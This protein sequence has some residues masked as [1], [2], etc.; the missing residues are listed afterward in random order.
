MPRLAPVTSTVWL[1]IFI[2]FSCPLFSRLSLVMACTAVRHRVRSST[3]ARRGKERRF[4]C[5]PRHG[6]VA[7]RRLALA[8]ED[9]PSGHSSDGSGNADH[10]E[11]GAE[12]VDARSRHERGR[13]GGDAGGAADLTHGLDQARRQPRRRF[14]DSRQRSD[15]G[16]GSAQSDRHPREQEGRKQIGEVAGVGRYPSE[17]EHADRQQRQAR[18]EQSPNA[19]DGN[20]PGA[21]DADATKAV[22]DVASQATPVLVGEY[23]RTCCISSDPRKMKEK[24]AL[25]AKNAERLAATSVRCFTA[26]AGTS[27]ARDRPRSARTATNSSAAAANSSSVV[28]A[29]QPS[30][31]PRFRP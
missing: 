2:A 11:G 13:H 19:D 23:P 20:K 22:T 3:R 27:G 6:D 28:I 9:E 25:K 21:G 29:V 5:G 30:S 1:A 17:P 26:A 15:L 14:G 8:W 7:F 12:A 18:D 31:A 10:D 16:R 4:S 24:N